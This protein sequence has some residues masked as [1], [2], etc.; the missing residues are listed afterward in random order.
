[1]TGDILTLLRQNLRREMND[2]ADD[3]STGACQDFA[4]YKHR[5]GVVEGLA[6]AERALL[7]LQEKI[8]EDD[9]D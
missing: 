2:I 3:V 4:D 7:D 9:D 6:R 1:L 8:E 5:V